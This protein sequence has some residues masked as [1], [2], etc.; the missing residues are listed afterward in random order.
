MR[1]QGRIQRLEVIAGALLQE[2]D[3]L[4]ERLPQVNFGAHTTTSLVGRSEKTM[5]LPAD[6]PVGMAVIAVKVSPS[7]WRLLHFNG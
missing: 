3:D 1:V 6:A 4:S 5:T 2:V 7:K